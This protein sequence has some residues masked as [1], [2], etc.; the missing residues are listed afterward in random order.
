MS[1]LVKR[2]GGLSLLA[3]PAFA[4]S[5]GGG[6]IDLSAIKGWFT[7]NVAVILWVAAAVAIAILLFGVVR[8]AGR[9]REGGLISIV[10][11]VVLA[12]CVGFALTWINGLSGQ[13]ITASGF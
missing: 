8:L 6:Q 11:G 10:V 3:A 4:Q 5:A 7:Q 1:K 13:A 2:L 9:D 12:I